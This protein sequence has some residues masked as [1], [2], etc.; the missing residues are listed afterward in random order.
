MTITADDLEGAADLCRLTFVPAVDADWNAPAG[1]IG[2]T[3]RET[4]D[5]IVSC[6]TFYASHLASR[7][8]ERLPRLRQHDP[9][10][11]VADMIDL[12]PAAAAVLAT[13]ARASGP[14]VRAFH[15]A[16]MADAEGFLAMG[17]DEILV[18]TGDIAAGLGVAFAPPAE[19]CAKVV[20]RLFPWAPSTTDPWATLLWANGRAPL[21]ER[22]RLD[23]DWCWQC[24]PLAEWDGNV[25][26]RTQAPTWTP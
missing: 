22:V 5:H 18:H 6:Q 14:D 26:R 16:G 23:P 8:V 13:V 12:V 20:A 9:D 17:C 24:A 7:A 1:D 2:Q 3:C 4:I 19:L 25:K 21:G 10:A 11:S 15:P